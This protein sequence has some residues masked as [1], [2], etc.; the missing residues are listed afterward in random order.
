MVRA[1]RIEA[2]TKEELLVLAIQMQ[3]LQGFLPRPLEQLPAMLASHPRPRLQIGHT[4]FKTGRQR[5]LAL[6]PRRIR[7]PKLQFQNAIFLERESMELF[8]EHKVAGKQFRKTH[9]GKGR[10][11][12]HRA[13]LE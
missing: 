12:L 13:G 2:A 3:D 5:L 11:G 9:A 8:A 4:C 6:A 1:Q 10:M 7:R